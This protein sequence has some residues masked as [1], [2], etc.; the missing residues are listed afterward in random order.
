MFNNDFV[1]IVFSKNKLQLVE[2]DASK[3]KIVRRITVDLPEG[4]IQNH[5]IKNVKEMSDFLKILWKKLSIKNSSV[6]II[7]P[8]FSTFIK[9]LTLPK[10]DKS[11]LDEAVRWQAS[12]FL[13]QNITSLSLDWR[14]IKEDEKNYLIDLVAIDRETLSS[15]VDSIVLAGLYPQLVE[16]PS[17]ALARIAGKEKEGRL[18][19]YKYFDETILLVLDGTSLVGSSVESTDNNAIIATA[20][21][22]VKHYNSVTFTKVMVGGVS[23]DKYLFSS[24]ANELKLETVVLDMTISAIPKEEIQNYIIPISLAFQKPKDPLDNKTINLLPE[25]EVNKYKNKRMFDQ[26]W[27]ILLVATFSIWTALFSSGGAY[28]YFSQ[29]INSLGSKNSVKLNVVKDTEVDRNKIKLINETSKKV[30]ASSKAILLPHSIINPIV[31]QMP[32]GIE[33]YVWDIDLDLGTVVLEG[34]S[35]N[36]ETLI[37]FKKQL[38]NNKDFKQ[39]SL[40]ISSFESETNIPFDL[41]FVYLPALNTNSRK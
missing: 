31:S 25:D 13:P 35:D 23:V 11:E 26:M 20:R 4:F 5:K 19:I 21:R 3:K 37:A 27:I 34:R 36:R 30:L 41:S 7:V 29:Q 14:I 24:L 28:L 8:E 9:N 6:G 38:E 17:I 40:P 22:I 18:V 33:I 32:E 1:S 39:I 12:D 10:L 2:L 15:Y 16:T